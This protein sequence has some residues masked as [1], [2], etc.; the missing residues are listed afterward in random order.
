MAFVL[1]LLLA[2]CG[3]GS[4]TTT[5]AGITTTTTTSIQS[6]TT[7]TSPST[8]A[9]TAATTT[10]ASLEL[11][12]IKVEDGVKTEGLDTISV[13]VGETVRFEVEADIADEVHVHG[14]DLSFETIPDEAVLVEFVADATGIFEVEI[15]GLALHIV[16]IEVTP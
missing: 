8:T 1:T 11:P 13:R 5:A 16:D 7:D 3:A 2:A 10:S 9:T 4:T 14:Y 6:T 15:E 12:L